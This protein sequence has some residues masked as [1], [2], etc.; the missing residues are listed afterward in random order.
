[1]SATGTIQIEQQRMTGVVSRDIQ[2]R[3]ISY[4]I[5]Q[6]KSRRRLLYFLPAFLAAVR[7]RV[8]CFFQP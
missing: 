6:H 3:G 1:M 7:A 2:I 8:I 4:A 5:L